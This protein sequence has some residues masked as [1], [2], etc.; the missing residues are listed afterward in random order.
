MW[1]I[2]WKRASPARISSINALKTKILFLTK[3]LRDDSFR[4][5]TLLMSREESIY[6]L[7]GLTSNITIH[8]TNSIRY[9]TSSSIL[10]RDG[11]FP[12]IIRFWSMFSSNLKLNQLVIFSAIRKLSTMNICTHGLRNYRIDIM[13]GNDSFL[14]F[15]SYRNCSSLIFSENIHNTEK[16]KLS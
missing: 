3:E 11:I 10:A 15:R 4:R 16:K 9:S 13:L 1:K 6:I 8:F 2:V 7:L 5:L 14:K 12:R